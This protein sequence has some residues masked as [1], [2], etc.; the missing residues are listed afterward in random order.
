MSQSFPVRVYYEDTDAG[1]IVYY[2]NYLKFA[3]RGRTEYLR[4]R[5]Y[6]NE[7]LREKDSVVFVARSLK[8]DYHHPARMDDLLDIKTVITQVRNASFTMQQSIFRHNELLF[9]MDVK[10]ACVDLHG[11]PVK[12]PKGIQQ[13]MIEGQE[14]TS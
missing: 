1:G 11:K 13:A 4:T 6:E 5:G 2:A 12:L 8:A 3:E 14:Q 9:S 7:T 10:L